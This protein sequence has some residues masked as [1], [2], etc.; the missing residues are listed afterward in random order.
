MVRFYLRIPVGSV[1]KNLPA[2][3]G[4]AGLIPGL[5]RSWRRKWQ[6][7]PVFLPGNPID[8]RAWWATVHE[9]SKRVGH[10][11]AAKQQLCYLINI[12]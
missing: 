5:G 1:V 7:S 10:D 6:P 2:I 8:R 12:A 3:A 11:L 9:V 4:L